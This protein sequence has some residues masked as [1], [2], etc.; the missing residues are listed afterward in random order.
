[1]SS[2]LIQT[3]SQGLFVMSSFGQVIHDAFQWVRYWRSNQIRFH[4][5]LARFWCTLRSEWSYPERYTNI[6]WGVD[7]N[8][9]VT[10]SI[11]PAWCDEIDALTNRFCFVKYFA[12]EY[13]FH[14]SISSNLLSIDFIIISLQ[15]A[16]SSQHIQRRQTVQVHRLSRFVI[17]F[18]FDSLL[19]T[20][21]FC[22]NKMG[23]LWRA[24][25]RVKVWLYFQNQIL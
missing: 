18:A 6:D 17:R 20:I 23:W 25:I 16:S 12:G 14:W 7:Q 9:H 3:D 8:D 1:M 15:V 22:P 19:G 21:L 11:G 5:W 4:V 2:A 24:V 13:G 10:Q